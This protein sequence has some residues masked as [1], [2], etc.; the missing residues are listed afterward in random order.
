V[1]ANQ[2][3]YN[4]ARRGVEW[5]LLPWC[6]EHGIPLM[7]YSPI[8]QARLARHP[9]LF[10]LAEERGV[11]PAQLA[12]AWLLR[13]DRVIAIPKASSVTHVEQN[14]AAL[15]C[16]LDAETLAEL[17]RLFPPPKRAMPLQML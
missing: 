6:E 15:E 1:A 10:A 3:L 5:D 17:D 4:L 9:G 16:P 2:V 14:F 11:A 13:G 12:L 8:E 7:A